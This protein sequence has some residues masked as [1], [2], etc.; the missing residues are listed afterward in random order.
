MFSNICDVIC[1]L[2]QCFYDYKIKYLIGGSVSSSLNG[3]FRT[4]NDIDVLVEKPL[5]EVPNVITALSTKFLV[6]EP[7]LIKQHLDNKAYNIFHEQTALKIDIFPGHTEFHQMQLSRALNVKPPTSRCEFKI[8]SAEDIIL[9]KLQWF[10]KSPSDRQIN[11]IVGVLNLNKN[12]VDL[13]Y[14]R[15]WASKLDVLDKLEELL[16]VAELV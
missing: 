2:A 10:Q 3:I 9:A 12:T 11:D 14:L 15:N 16:C 13:S 6:D 1:D 7:A 8:A 5:N 4:T